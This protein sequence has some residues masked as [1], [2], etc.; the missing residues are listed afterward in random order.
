MSSKYTII[1]DNIYK[2]VKQ[3]QIYYHYHRFESMEKII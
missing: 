1:Y 2:F 3:L